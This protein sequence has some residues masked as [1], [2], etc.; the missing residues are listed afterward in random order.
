[1]IE[2]TTIGAGGGSIASVDRGGL[3]QVGPES[4]GSMPGPACYGQGNERPTLTDAHVV[5]GRINADKPIG[6]KLARL[7]AEAAKRAIAAPVEALV[8]VPLRP[9]VVG[10]LEAWSATSSAVV[11]SPR[12]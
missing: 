2:I 9:P 12:G 5:L 7:D 1:M 6:G 8:T 3:L 4:A 10:T 11:D